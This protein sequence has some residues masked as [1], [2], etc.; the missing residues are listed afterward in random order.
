MTVNHREKLAISHHLPGLRWDYGD[1]LLNTQNHPLTDN[2]TPI[3]RNT[4]SKVSSVILPF[5]PSAL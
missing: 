1:S 2:R 4:P 3:A 5:G